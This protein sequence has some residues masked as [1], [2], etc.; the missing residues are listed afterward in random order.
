VQ[1]E[2]VTAIVTSCR[3]VVMAHV[4]LLL[5]TDVH[6]F[7]VSKRVCFI[8]PT[9]DVACLETPP[10]VHERI[11]LDALR[12]LSPNYSFSE[13]AVDELVEGNRITDSGQDYEVPRLHFDNDQIAAGRERLA[14]VID[15]VVSLADQ[16]KGARA[17]NLLGSA[18]HSL[19][20]FYSHST[21]VNRGARTVV[22]LESDADTPL[23]VSGRSDTD[24]CDPRG[25]F[26]GALNQFEARVSTGYWR[27]LQD[28][29]ADLP[30]VDPIPVLVNGYY[31]CLHGGLTYG[32]NKDTLIRPLHQLA[33]DLAMEGTR[34]YL[35]RVLEAAAARSP[36]ALCTLLGRRGPNC[37]LRIY[38]IFT[39]AV[40]P[41]NPAGREAT[42][43]TVTSWPQ[44]QRIVQNCTLTT[45]FVF[46]TDA[47]NEEITFCRLGASWIPKSRYRATRQQF[48]IPSN[49]AGSHL[50]TFQQRIAVDADGRFSQREGW[51]ESRDISCVTPS[52]TS[53]QVVDRSAT[54]MVFAYESGGGGGRLRSESSDVTR[55]FNALG[56]PTGV[57][58]IQTTGRTISSSNWQNLRS[59]F[60]SNLR[61]IS[62]STGVTEI[63]S[64][65]Y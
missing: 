32:I 1:G 8:T 35:L 19:Q 46:P 48:T 27:G 13:P 6:A 58:D 57:Q 30:G 22:A 10:G 37:E 3:L 12:A 63:P 18:L 65:C 33:R 53:T 51:T 61:L 4:L 21:W 55:S 17:R 36:A 34:R 26:T 14:D 20:D 44:P 9:G 64:E 2:I 52:G 41:T 24:F 59:P 47:F 11:T 50:R 43:L 49:C 45:N 5:C 40:R 16:G 15:T 56:Q 39:S 60:L 29:E 23:L 25:T 28:L 31:R 42:C 54:N 38:R 62:T 7:T